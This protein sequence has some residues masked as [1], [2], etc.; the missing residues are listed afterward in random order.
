MTRLTLT[1]IEGEA[2][3]TPGLVAVLG[4]LPN[5][6]YNVAIT[7]WKRRR[8]L[9][10]NAL[11]WKWYSCLEDAFGQPKEDWHSYFK[12]RYLAR[13]AQVAGK[14]VSFPGSTAALTRQEMS[15]YME[16]IQAHVA[17]EWGIT[18]PLPGQRGYDDFCIL[19]Q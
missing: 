1:K 6:S 4:T 12:A 5:G 8:S 11:M 17:T 14:E 2:T 7:P 13:H 10:Q 3:F 16:Q 9:D 18:L 15:R 19:Y